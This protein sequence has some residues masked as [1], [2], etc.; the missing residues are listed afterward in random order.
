M[1]RSCHIHWSHVPKKSQGSWFFVFFCQE[2]A[3]SSIF[4]TVTMTSME[5]PATYT[6]FP[7]FNC[8]AND[9][10]GLKKPLIIFHEACF[11][12]A[13]VSQESGFNSWVHKTVCIQRLNRTFLPSDGWIEALSFSCAVSVFINLISDTTWII[14]SRTFS[15]GECST[16][17]CYRCSQVSPWYCIISLA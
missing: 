9:S 11:N 16:V 2:L 15:G 6:K 4:T 10:G 17:A 7:T 1:R 8:P 3:L 5:C 13:I 12:T 14:S